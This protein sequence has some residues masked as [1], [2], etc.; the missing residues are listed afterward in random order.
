[1]KELDLS[2]AHRFSELLIAARKRDNHDKIIGDSERDEKAI[3]VTGVKMAIK[4]LK[5]LIKGK[6]NEKHS[7]SA[8]SFV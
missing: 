2:A 7:Q 1:M 8:K 4:R 5:K 6:R 3:Q